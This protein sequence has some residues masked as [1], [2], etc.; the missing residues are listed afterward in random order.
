MKKLRHKNFL[1]IFCITLAVILNVW[2][3]CVCVC[4]SSMNIFPYGPFYD[5][6]WFSNFE[7]IYNNLEIFLKYTYIGTLTNISWGEERG[8]REVYIFWK[9]QKMAHVDTDLGQRWDSLYSDMTPL[10]KQMGRKKI[11]DYIAGNHKKL[12]MKYVVRVLESTLFP[13]LQTQARSPN[14][15]WRECGLNGYIKVGAFSGYHLAWGLCTV[16]M[17]E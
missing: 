4:V 5:W 12:A 14:A 11:W 7:Y 1:M 9:Q 16:G 13:K 15:T 10:T 3:V 17:R 6:Q 8:S 2:C